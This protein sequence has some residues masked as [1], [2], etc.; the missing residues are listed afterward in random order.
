VLA[1]ASRASVNDLVERDADRIEPDPVIEAYKRD[2][3]HSLLVENLKKS[4][5][6]RVRGLMQLQRL[7][8]EARRA[9]RKLRGH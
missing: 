2:V 1:S 4:P 3:D 9:G 8:E 7:A 5:E 6:A